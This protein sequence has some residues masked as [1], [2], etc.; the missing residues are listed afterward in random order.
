MIAEMEKNTSDIW[1]ESPSI[2][3][4]ELSFREVLCQSGS[5][6]DL[7]LDDSVDWFNDVWED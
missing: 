7:V 1:Y 5:T 6:T 4:G 3:P 2:V